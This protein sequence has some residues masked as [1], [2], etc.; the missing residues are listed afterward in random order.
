MAIRPN[1]IQ[2]CSATD[3]PC[4]SI[5]KVLPDEQ[6]DSTGRQ[7]EILDGRTVLERTPLGDVIDWRGAEA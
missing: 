4:N 3:P 7:E 5:A 6:L 2:Q 1:I